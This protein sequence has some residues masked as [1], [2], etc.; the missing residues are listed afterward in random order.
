M[1]YL[2]LFFII[3]YKRANISGI[4]PKQASIPHQTNDRNL[5]P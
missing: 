1:R 2:P 3:I 4:F 5:S